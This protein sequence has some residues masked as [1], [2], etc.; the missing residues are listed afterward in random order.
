MI[1]LSIV[2]PL[3]MLFAL[4][5]IQL[6]RPDFTKEVWNTYA[7][8]TK[9]DYCKVHPN[10]H[11]YCYHQGPLTI[12]RALE[13]C[14]VLPVDQIKNVFYYLG[15]AALYSQPLGLVLLV[16]SSLC[17]A[18][19]IA[20]IQAWWKL[21]TAG[22]LPVVSIV[23][24]IIGAVLCIIERNVPQECHQ[25]E[26]PQQLQEEQLEEQQHSHALITKEEEG[27]AGQRMPFYR[28]IFNAVP[29][30]I[31]FVLLSVTYSLS[32]LLQL[33]FSERCKINPWGYNAFNQVPLTPFIFLTFLLADAFHWTKLDWMHLGTKDTQRESFWMALRTTYRECTANRCQGFWIMF[34]YRSLI[35]GRGVMYT[36]LVTMYDLN[37]VYL[38]LTLIRV[39]LSWLAS[40]FILLVV[41]KFIRTSNHEKK[42]ILHPFNMGAKIVGSIC[43]V[44]S[45]VLLE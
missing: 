8:G 28:T 2:S 3:Q 24:G 43:I 27:N 36:Y 1:A 18:F 35:N 30:L 23:L 34:I 42:V 21:G 39:V 44:V 25:E 5:A 37:K 29:L 10:Q 41:P 20:P 4:G 12:Y 40:L 9:Y 16:M 38:Q 45:L 32:F 11:Q 7:N 33:Y 6:M 15:E 17:S 26:Q 19:I 22:H 14:P 13:V 31:P